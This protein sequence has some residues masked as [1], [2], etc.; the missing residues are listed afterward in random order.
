M[1]CYSF[2]LSS[3]F[4]GAKFESLMK[5]NALFLR[6]REASSAGKDSYIKTFQ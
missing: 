2:V 1:C 4:L 5:E 6:E 3:L